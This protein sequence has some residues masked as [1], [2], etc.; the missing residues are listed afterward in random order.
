MIIMNDNNDYNKRVL[1]KM[2]NCLGDSKMSTIE[3][4]HMEK[5]NYMY[6]SSIIIVQNK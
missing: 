5:T 3:S 6:T 4:H 1:M 2:I